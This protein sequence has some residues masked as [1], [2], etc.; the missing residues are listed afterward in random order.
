MW[1]VA[2]ENEYKSLM[3]NKNWRLVI[4]PTDR[5][6][7]K[8]KWVLK[9]KPSYDGVEER[10]KARLVAKGFTQIFGVD[11]WETFAPVLKYDSLRAILATVAARDLEINLLDIKTA[12]LYGKLDEEIL[13]EQPEGYVEKGKENSCVSGVTLGLKQAT[14]VWNT[15]FNQFLLL[16]VLT[17]CQSDPC[18]YYRFI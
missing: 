10:Y 14:R 2:I 13:M 17:R 4:R 12:F 3:D 15:K 8:S 6:V 18:V 11:Y 1:K 5:N 7:I 16:F 9:V